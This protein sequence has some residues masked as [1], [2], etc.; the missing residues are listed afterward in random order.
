MQ[1]FI[2]G[3]VDKPNKNGRIYPRGVMDKAIKDYRKQI[4]EKR[5]VGELNPQFDP[6]T[7]LTNVSHIITDLLI[8]ENNLVA[9]VDVLTTPRGLILQ[10]MLESHNIEF[11]TRG[12]AKLDK[13][14]TITEYTLLSVDACV[15]PPN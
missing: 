5:S 10:D 4:D 1:T 6:T 12:L 13:E 7:V 11:V 9:D 3:L 2:V 8:E 15:A 14:K